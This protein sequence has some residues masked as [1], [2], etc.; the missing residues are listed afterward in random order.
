[1]PSAATV[2]EANQEVTV[3]AAEGNHKVAIEK[4]EALSGDAQKACKDQAD[5]AYK[6]DK[7]NAE[8]RAAQARPSKRNLCWRFGDGHLQ[9]LPSSLQSC[10]GSRR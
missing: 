7:A 9:T 6:T 1:M 3:A 5:A 10:S 2:A 4:C 8:A